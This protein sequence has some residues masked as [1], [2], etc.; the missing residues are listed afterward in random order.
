MINLLSPAGRKTALVLSLSTLAAGIF[1]L[2]VPLK[3][4]T[5]YYRSR[6]SSQQIEQRLSKLE[7]DREAN[8][9]KLSR[10]Q[11]VQ[12]EILKLRDTYIYHKG[13]PTELRLDLEKILRDIGL[14]T[15]PLEYVYEDYP[16]QGFRKIQMSFAIS[17]SYT[18]VRKIIHAIETF[19]KFLILE[20]VEFI[21]IDNQGV[22]IRLR[23]KMAG[24]YE[25]SNID[26]V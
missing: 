12:S 21:D 22:S 11:E 23:L 14:R 6:Q 15:P 17:G 25:Q 20:R 18:Q 10:W 13:M 24:F 2:S 26:G 19:P 8:L 9:E 5:A 3:K 1:F 16:D 7:K 4:R